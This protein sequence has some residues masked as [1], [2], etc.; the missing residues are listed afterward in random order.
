MKKLLR[1]SIL[2]IIPAAMFASNGMA[3][4]SEELTQQEWNKTASGYCQIFFPDCSDLDLGRRLSYAREGDIIC[5]GE[6]GEYTQFYKATL[7]DANE[8]FG[9]EFEK[10]GVDYSDE[11]SKW[12][13]DNCTQ[14]CG[15]LP[16]TTE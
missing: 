5:T 11:L 4:C 6:G 13:F 12:L 9:T 1:I 15:P 3:Q 10:I 16:E 7:Q 8:L 14:Y 2:S